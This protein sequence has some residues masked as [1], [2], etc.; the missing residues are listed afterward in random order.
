MCNQLQE[1]V[2]IV[3][4]AYRYIKIMLLV[5]TPLQKNREVAHSGKW[6]SALTIIIS[7]LF[8]VQEK[9]LQL[10]VLE[11]ETLIYIFRPTLKHQRPQEEKQKQFSSLNEWYNRGIQAAVSKV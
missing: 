10:P 5:K 9:P 1:K 4:E 6:A 7:Q 8:I 11:I 3:G 2:I